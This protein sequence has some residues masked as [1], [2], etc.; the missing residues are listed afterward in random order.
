MLPLI[1]LLLL[2]NTRSFL[3]HALTSLYSPSQKPLIDSLHPFLSLLPFFSPRLQ[4]SLGSIPGTPGPIGD[5]LVCVVT[6]RTIPRWRH[7]MRS[8]DRTQRKREVA[9]LD[10]WGAEEWW[11]HWYPLRT[12]AV[13]RGGQSLV[14]IQ[15]LGGF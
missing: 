2:Q 15:Q 13:L 9:P 8:L 4:M 10:R 1:S 14:R 5:V 3:L 12:L 7:H 11:S 6:P